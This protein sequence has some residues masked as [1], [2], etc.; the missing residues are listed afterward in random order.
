[1]IEHIANTHEPL[2]N[3][4]VAIS[5]KKDVFHFRRSIASPQPKRPKITD[6][7]IATL[8]PVVSIVSD[9]YLTDQVNLLTFKQYPTAHKLL[10]KAM[11]VPLPTLPRFL[12]AFE[13]EA[14]TNDDDLVFVNILRCILTDFYSKC[15]R[16]PQYQPKYE[17]T[18]WVD[19]VVPIFQA[20]GDHSQLL[21]FQWCEVP[22]EEHAEF[23]IDPTTW[24]PGVSNKFHDGLGY[25]NN[26]CNKLIMEG[27]SGYIDK[28]NVQR[29]QDDTI[30]I[31]HASIELL[32][33]LI[34]RHL[35]ASFS[36][37]CLINS[38]SVQCVCTSI[39][40]STTSLDPED[41]GAYIHTQVRSA[42]IPLNYDSRVSWTAIFELLAY[43]FTCLKEQK[44]VLETVTK[45]STGL[46]PV[47]D[48][49]RGMNVLPEIDGS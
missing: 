17:R 40:L 49:D 7:T 46:L 25:D 9:Q 5:T 45:E 13:I 41:P 30:K 27:S 34:R 4:D 10:V 32:D 3:D 21:G 2:F 33:S 22:T 14:N 15:Q 11:D 16:N 23:T 1:M 43:L 44:L 19:R 18:F 31:I 36:S 37:L 47:T 12:W 29:S 26:N 6:K 20:L 48:G 8:S 28:E 35:S 39:T 42:D 24:K 38:F